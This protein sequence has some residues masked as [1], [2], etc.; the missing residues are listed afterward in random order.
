MKKIQ[1]LLS[2]YNG[3]KFI[4]EQLDSYLALDNFN[5][6]KVLIRDDGSSDSTVEIL[7]EYRNKYG[8]EVLEG[9][10]IG[11]NASMHELILRR[12]KSCSYFAFSDQDDV[13]LPDKL[14]SAVNF[15]EEQKCSAP[16]LYAAM[17]Y[18]TDEELHITGKTFAP[19]KKLS[20]YNAI[21]QN[22]CI[23]HT[24]VFNE[25]LAVL[26]DRNYPVDIYTRI[27][28][29]DY[30]TYML[31]GACGKVVFE[32]KP[33]AL[34]RQHGNNVV[35]YKSGVRSLFM[36]LRRALTT[37]NANKNSRQLKA[38]LETYSDIIPEEYKAEG[39]KFLKK[40]KN[41]FTRLGY[42]L[43][44]K[45]YRQTRGENLIFRLMYLFGKYKIKS[46]KEH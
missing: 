16:L 9:N 3:E 31:A 5:N 42:V 2:T 19:Q 13:W 40:Q 15:I 38:F 33:T 29:I 17:S 1:I 10:N 22:V 43:T 35:G 4:R 44:T 7:R 11:L 32:F 8:F 41:V 27:H 12:D 14:S 34:Y 36:R 25:E 20:F 23:G 45:A 26:L 24:S 39:E 28:I 21:T 30:W 6:V 37:D 18:I 46:K